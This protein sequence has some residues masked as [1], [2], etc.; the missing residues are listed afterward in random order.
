M[1]FFQI[2]IIVNALVSCFWFIWIH[3]LWVYRH[4]KYFIFFLCG[5]RLYTSESD[6]YRRHILTYKDDPRTGRVKYSLEEE[7]GGERA[8]SRWRKS[9][10]SMEK[11]PILDGERAHSRWSKSPFSHSCCWLS[12]RDV[13]WNHLIS[14][15]CSCSYDDTLKY[16]SVWFCLFG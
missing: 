13:W 7:I 8:H 15:S 2:E 14:H 9:P 10:F 6:V 3:M 16:C 12:L 5:D 4:W 11:E 1:G